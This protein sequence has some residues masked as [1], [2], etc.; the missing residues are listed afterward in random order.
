MK[1]ALQ[2]GGKKATNWITL[3]MIFSKRSRLF[4]GTSH[5][6]RCL[7]TSQQIQD[8]V[9]QGFIDP[10]Y[11]LTNYVLT[12]PETSGMSPE[13]KPCFCEGKDSNRLPTIE[14]S[15]ASPS[16]WFSRWSSPPRHNWFTLLE[17]CVARCIMC[18]A[19]PAPHLTGVPWPK[20]YP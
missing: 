9:H 17:I 7:Y 5:H 19:V 16:C 15:G 12:A 6:L 2:L 10:A 13:K 1:S 3:V 4:Q 20:S 14:F 8:V 11:T 18:L